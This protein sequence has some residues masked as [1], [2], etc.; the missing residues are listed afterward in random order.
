MC[1]ERTD[2][3][4]EDVAFGL[5]VLDAVGEEAEDGADPEQHGEAAE[6][7]PAELDPLG[8]R[9]GRRQRVRSI[10]CQVDLGLSRRQTLA[11]QNN[12]HQLLF[13]N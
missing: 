13:P 8:R 6:E 1:A 5:A 7:L 2:V 10:A 4:A 12:V 3:V 9:L 11:K